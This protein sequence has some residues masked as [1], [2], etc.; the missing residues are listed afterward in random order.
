M[1]LRFYIFRSSIFTNKDT[2]YRSAVYVIIIVTYLDERKKWKT[3]ELIFKF[4]VP[5]DIKFPK[6]V[7]LLRYTYIFLKAKSKRYLVRGMTYCSTPLKVMPLLQR[8]GIIQPWKT[9][10]NNSAATA[11]VMQ[12]VCRGVLSVLGGGNS[13]TRRDTAG[14]VNSGSY[15]SEVVPVHITNARRGQLR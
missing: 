11:R 9:S 7:W 1:F 15:F 2:I 4:D 10:R 14:R 8:S 3:H 6:N 13:G 5:C 12:N